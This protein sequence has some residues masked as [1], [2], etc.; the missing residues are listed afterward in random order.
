MQSPRGLVP[1][2]RMGSGSGLSGS[3]CVSSRGSLSNDVPE[4]TTLDQSILASAISSGMPTFLL[5]T[6]VSSTF[7]KG[8]VK[9]VGEE[10][11]VVE[12]AL[13]K[14]TYSNQIYLCITPR[15]GYLLRIYL[16]LLDIVTLLGWT[17]LPFILLSS[18]KHDSM[19]V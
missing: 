10:E 7:W 11:L 12:L 15:L 9:G 18:S 4:S 17:L 6:G 3:S 5:T 2:S 13:C 14:V 1:S 16:R 8:Y 19:V